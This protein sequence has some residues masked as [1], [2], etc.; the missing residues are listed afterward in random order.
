MKRGPVPARHTDVRSVILVVLAAVS[1]VAQRPPVILVDGYHLLCSN[2]DLSSTTDFGD[3]QSRL[4]AEGVQVVF[5][6]TCSISGKP[7]IE[8]LGD[9]LGAAIAKLDVP[10]VDVITHSMGG[11]VMRC[12]LA[13][14]QT[15]SGMF[16][17]PADPKVRKWV[18]IATPNFGALIPSIVADF[19]PDKQAKEMVPGSQFLFD[20]ATW[21]QNHDD[22]RG[23]DA[24]GIIGNAGGVGPVE[25]T[26]DG[27]VAVTSASM[28]FAL[29]DIKTRVLPY[30]H[31]SGDLTSVLGLGCDGP[32]LAKL[33]SDN[34][35]S[36]QIIDSFLS[37]TGT[38][39]TIGHSPLQ[40]P[41]LA[42]YGGVLSQ[43]RDASDTPTGGI[44]DQVLATDA[45]MPGGYS[46]VVDK[47]G[48]EIALVAPS[49]ARLPYLS[50]APGMLISV[51]GQALSGA[52]VSLNDQPLSIGYSSDS[53]VNALMPDAAPGIARLAVRTPSGVQTI[54]VLVEDAAP[55]VF[56]MDGSGTGAAAAIRTGSYVSLYLTGL[57]HTQARVFLDGTELPVTYSGPAPGYPGLNQVNAQLPAAGA[58]G[59]VVVL[60]GRRISNLVQLQ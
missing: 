10:Q 42:K 41:L 51:Y 19:L 8:Q 52:T 4:E 27:T 50:L 55:A 35:L 21:N 47:P 9:A 60:A 58:S 56:T 28:S 24:I 30:C 44:R 43:S 26:S 57:G 7:P 40:D 36:W 1:A 33:Q 3:L 12:Y 14:K 32:P 46:V 5:V 17:P 53:Q 34:P 45:P 22:L 6:P 13:G 37:G 59:T 31:G 11:L 20:L 15:N 16:S 54:N 18:S 38:W 25:K 48:P 23:V 49:A 29:S 39:S 2:S